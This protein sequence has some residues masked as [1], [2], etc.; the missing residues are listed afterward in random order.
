[1]RKRYSLIL[2]ALIFTVSLIGCSLSSV[3]QFF[4]YVA[5]GDYEK[6]SEFV[7]FYDEYT[8]VGLEEHTEEEAKFIWIK[9][10]NDLEEQ[11]I[12]LESYQDLE[13]Y[14]DDG[15]PHGNV[16]LVIAA[17]DEKTKYEV[18][19]YLIPQDSVKVAGLI[20]PEP[21]SVLEQFADVI[22]GKID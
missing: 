3:D 11:G 22:S 12:Y 13:L 17:D 21:D 9:R 16:E 1:M 18:R 2:W 7:A 20:L 10:M 6:A 14:R 19:L 5:A 15:Y 4:D 8:D